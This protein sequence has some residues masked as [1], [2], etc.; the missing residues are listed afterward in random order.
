M[1]NQH[2]L[3]KGYRDL[4]EGEIHAMNAVKS[5][6]ERIG[7]LFE[8]LESNESLDQRWIVIAKSDIQKGFMSAI[9]AIAQ[10]TSF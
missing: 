10:P 6:A 2:K 4:S 1:E 7:I 5:E 3:I 8:E 9:R